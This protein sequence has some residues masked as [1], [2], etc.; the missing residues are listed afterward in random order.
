MADASVQRIPVILDTDIGSD[1]DD[2]WALAYLLKSPELDPQLILTC[3]CDT[4]YR[5]RLVAK[6]LQVAGRT[7]IPIGIGLPGAPCHEY[8]KPWVADFSLAAYPGRIYRDGV[9]QLIELVHASPVPVTLIAI[10]PTGNVAE[11]LRRDPSIAPKVRYVGMQGSIDVGYGGGPPVAEANVKG[12]VAAFR[13]VLNADW[14]DLRI[15]PLDT[16]GDVVLGR[17]RYQRIR[18]S[19][20]PGMRALME[21]YRIWASL[22]TWINADFLETR[23]STLFDLVALFMAHSSDYLDFETVRLKVTD[24]GI[25]VRDPEG[26]PVK[27]AMAWKDQPAFLTHLAERLAGSAPAATA[28]VKA[29]DT[30]PP[31]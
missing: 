16:C 14:L 27:V 29:P 23:S 26:V 8:Q 7:D 3:T 6:F 4:E 17:E 2:T 31:R 20:D 18:R 12:N 30:Q 24:D 11:A 1:I 9:H 15:T 13:E 25:T 10:G 22:V 21:N 19:P 5:A 28:P